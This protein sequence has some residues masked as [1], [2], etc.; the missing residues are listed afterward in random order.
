VN[1]IAD[2]KGKNGEFGDRIVGIE[3]GAGE[4]KAVRTKV[5]PK[6]GLNDYDL[7]E[8]SSPAMLASLDTAIKGKK[9]VVV[10]LWQPHW[11]FTR[12]QLKPLEDPLGAWGKPDDMQAI[13]TKGFG[14]DHA[15]VAGWMKNF[16]MKPEQLAG[17]MFKLHELGQGKEQAGAKQWISEN[18][19]LVDSWVGGS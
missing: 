6:Y 17:L 18:T 9:P 7:V 3:A 19:A 16:T 2:L 4:M 10:T 5:I 1:S 8:G 11:A 12:W 14:K 13:A 15:E